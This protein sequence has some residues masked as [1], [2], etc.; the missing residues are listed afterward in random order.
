VVNYL[1]QLFHPNLVKL[2]GY[3]W[4]WEDEE[5]LLVFLVFEYMPRGSLEHHLFRR[6]SHFQPLPW[7]LRMKVALEVARGLGFLHSDQA[8]VIYRD[9]RTS[10]ILLDSEYNA[11]LSGFGLAKDGPSGYTSYIPTMLMG[12]TSMGTHGYA[13][14]EYIATGHL[15]AKCDVYSYGVVLLEL[16]SGQRALDKNRPPGQHKLVEWARPYITNKRRVFRFLDSRLGSQYCR[17]AAQKTA[18]LAL[19]CLSM[20]PRH[21]PGM[22]QVVTLLEGL[23]DTK[24][25]LKSS[26]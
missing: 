7:N 25:A 16:L 17:P 5:R 18:A 21:R 12:T 10:N 26:K 8:K 1:G 11:K 15:T 20:D 3:C 24:S 23:Q 19:Q 13:A 6:G 14:P 2:I 4:D 9:F 22:D